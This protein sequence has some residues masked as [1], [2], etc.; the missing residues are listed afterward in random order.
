MAQRVLQ[1]AVLR[2]GVEAVGVQH[3][4]GAALQHLGQDRLHSGAAAAA[5]HHMQ[6]FQRQALEFALHHIGRCAV[7]G[8]AGQQAQ[9][10]APRTCVQGGGGRQNGCA[11]HV[12]AVWGHAF[13]TDHGHIAVAAFVAGVGLGC[14]CA[15]GIE[16]GQWRQSVLAGLVA[17]VFEPDLATGIA[18]MPH[19]QTGLHRDEAQGVV[20]PH[21]QGVAGFTIQPLARLRVQPGGHVDGQ[22]RSCALLHGQHASLQVSTQGPRGTDA[23]QGVDAQIFCSHFLQPFLGQVRLNAHARLLR[24]L[25][26]RLC[27]GWAGSG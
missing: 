17:Q 27:I 25:Q 14:C 23:Q 15:G 12:H 18:P 16:P 11:A 22:H 13:A 2:H 21:G 20:C 19:E 10:D 6:F 9:D 5:A 7:A 4:T 26:G 24:P 8:V 3:Q 1:C